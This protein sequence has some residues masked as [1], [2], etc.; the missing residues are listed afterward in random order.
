M[1]FYIAATKSVTAEQI[2]SY[3]VQGFVLVPGL[4]KPSVVQR[5][6]GVLSTYVPTVETGALHQILSAAPLLECVTKSVCAAAANLAG[7]DTRLKPPTSIYTVTVCPQAGLWEWPTPHIDH[8]RPEDRHR[9]LP[10]PYRVGCLI[11]LNNVASHSGA[12]VVWPGS[13]RQLMDL[14]KSDLRKYEFLSSLNQDI[15]TLRLNDP[16]EISA[17]AGDT[18]FYDYLCAHSGSKNIGTTCRLALGHKW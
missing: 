15:Q 9:T 6:Y 11:Y 3:H 13:H 2:R 17:R 8:A 10:P 5:A 18:L 4:I 7:I 14:A 1:K 12:T 16:V